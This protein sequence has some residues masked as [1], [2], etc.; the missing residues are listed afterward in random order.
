MALR[1]AIR[2]VVKL[3]YDAG[4]HFITVGLHEQDPNAE[5]FHGLP[6]LNFN[7]E[8]YVTDLSEYNLSFQSE[9]V[10][11]MDFSLI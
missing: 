1:K 10:T 6:K 3:A 7:S 4:Y 11:A 9:D 8:M 5:A 2:A